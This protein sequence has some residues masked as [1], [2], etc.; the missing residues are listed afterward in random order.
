MF[1]KNGL[2]ALLILGAVYLLVVILIRLLSSR[3]ANL[4]ETNGRLAACPDSPNC[5]SSQANDE[6]HRCPPLDYTGSGPEAMA[7]LKAVLADQ[8][9]TRLV[10]ETDIYLHAEVTSAVLRFVDDV[11]FV[12]DDS[13]KLIHCRSAARVGYSDFGVNRRRMETIAR[14]FRERAD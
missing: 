13:H 7:R 5:V 6:A 9:R 1:W 8:P 12:L 11:E 3:P 10:T 14:R 4:G 2:K